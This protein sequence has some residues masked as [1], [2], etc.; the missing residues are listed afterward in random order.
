MVVIYLK[1][2]GESMKTAKIY[3]IYFQNK[4]QDGFDRKCEL[5][6]LNYGKLSCKIFFYL[7]GL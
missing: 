7:K 4:L 3:S 5:K 1:M 2:G 6:E